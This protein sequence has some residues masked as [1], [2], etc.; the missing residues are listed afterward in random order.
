MNYKQT[1]KLIMQFDITTNTGISIEER[2]RIIDNECESVIVSIIQEMK[3]KKPGVVFPINEILDR[4]VLLYRLFNPEYYNIVNFIKEKCTKLFLRSNDTKVGLVEDIELYE[5][6]KRF[7]AFIIST[8]ELYYSNFDKKSVTFENLISIVNNNPSY[9]R[10]VRKNSNFFAYVK[11]INELYCYI[12]PKGTNNIRICLL[13]YKDEVNEY[14]K[15]LDKIKTD[16]ELEFVR[17][18]TEYCDRTKIYNLNQIINDTNIYWPVKLQQKYKKS[19]KILYGD[20][21]KLFRRYFIIKNIKNENFIE[22]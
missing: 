1:N 18:I 17:I 7:A 13:K 16:N 10:I 22:L 19:D 14:D 2:L 8:L 3:R 11:S 4:N 21:L 6:S 15:N 5:E 20:L 12:Y 9:L